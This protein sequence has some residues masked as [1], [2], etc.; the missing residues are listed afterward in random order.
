MDSLYD[1]FEETEASFI[2]VSETWF[3]Y[4]EALEKIMSDAAHGH[5]VGL[6]NSCR[7]RLKRANPGGG[8]SI[9]FCTGRISLREYPVKTKGYEIIAATGKIPGT[10]GTLFI[11]ALYL[12]TRLKKKQSE[13][14]LDTV[15]DIINKI[16][17][18]NQ[19]AKVI[20]AGDF[21]RS[22]YTRITDYFDDIELVATPPTRQHAHLDMVLSNLH[23]NVT[24]TR[25]MPPLQPDDGKLGSRSDHEFV[26]VDM[27][28]RKLHDFKVNKYTTRIITEETAEKL[29]ESLAK[30]SWTERIGTVEE[31]G[32]DEYT[33]RF[34]EVL[35][36]ALNVA[37]PLKTRKV[38]ST[39]KPWITDNI[40]KMVRRR[41]AVFRN[42]GRRIDWKKIK[43][44][45]RRMISK[46][47]REYYV[48]AAA[49]LSKPGSHQLPYKALEKIRHAQGPVTFD[50]RALAP[51]KTEPELADDL[52]DYFSD[53]SQKFAPLTVEVLPQIDQ[54]HDLLDL[55]TEEVISALTSIKKPKTNVSIDP[56]SRLVN[57]CAH[58]TA[59]PLRNIYNAVL[60]GGI[61]P[62]LWKVEEVSVIP[63]KQRPESYGELRNIS[64]TSIYS[65]VLEGFMV[66]RI[67][68][69]TELRGNQYGGAKGCGASHLLTELTTRIAE[70][71]EDNDTAAAV[72]SIDFSKAFNRMDHAAC[73]RALKYKGASDSTVRMVGGF[74]ID[75]KMK[76]KTGSIFSNV[77]D[78]PG[79]APQGTCSGNL[80]FSTTIDEIETDNFRLIHDISDNPGV[81]DEAAGTGDNRPVES[82]LGLTDLAT[83]L[84]AGAG[85]LA[86]PC[87]SFT[88]NCAALPRGP[89]AALDSSFL[90]EEW[91]R[92]RIELAL[93]IDRNPSVLTFKYVDD[94]TAV[95]FVPTTAGVRHISTQREVRKIH[96][97][98]LQRVYDRVKRNAG[99][100]GMEVHPDKTQLLAVCPSANFN[101]SLFITDGDK[102]ILSTDR[103]RTLGVTYNAK[104]TFDEH[105]TSLKRSFAARSW[106]VTH[107]KS[108]GLENATISLVYKMY[109]RPILEYAVEA[110]ASLLTQEQ[111]DA[112]E[113]C[114]RLALKT[115][116][117]QKTSYGRC[118]ELAGLEEL[119]S[120]RSGL[121]RKFALKTF[122]N[123]R[124]TWDWF[125]SRPQP[126]YSLR[127]REEIEEITARTTRLK[128]APINHMRKIL[129]KET[130]LPNRTE[131]SE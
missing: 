32:I 44:Y 82:E 10:V 86:S 100:I 38:K 12:S 60:N 68:Q 80:L 64:C 22:D 90:P 37:A 73:L 36:E 57:A 63:K 97:I 91:D 122:Q 79:G 59:E 35:T 25:Y 117:G 16:K 21:N 99:F 50:I 52:A 40:R 14:F 70:G 95:E 65:K 111:S 19:N 87:S 119:R 23:D 126:S 17:S 61:W 51:D 75:R 46:K 47:K 83:R 1:Y 102:E 48:S 118:L 112:L 104:L 54:P 94:F 66:D 124:F 81:P 92:S 106:T 71:I 101:L 116:Y 20:V 6:I 15:Q 58:A 42:R 11:V 72:L 69:E 128:N 107:L 55:D 76:I 8:V 45:T 31:Q 123:T 77:R 93:D 108:V 4:C 26:Y 115:I 49:D 113:R 114:Q 120:R 53:I 129:N 39:D 109:V 88:A 28:L 9:A 98:G 5:G 29:A 127:N 125:P 85:A 96:A 33:E 62:R 78:M 27:E 30:I 43:K 41:K 89:R 24:S 13:D 2:V 34:H 84:L 105:V 74:L 130:D 110:F 67:Q 56:P 18:E 121:V 3:Y 7:K 131:E 103:L